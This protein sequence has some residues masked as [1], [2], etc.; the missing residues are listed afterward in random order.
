MRVAVGWKKLDPKQAETGLNHSVFLNVAWDA[1]KPVGMGRIIGDGGYMYLIADVMV[2]PEYQ[3]RGIGRQL[4]EN[5]NAWLDNL[6][7][8]GLCIMVNLM[9]TLGKEEFYQKSGYEV[10]PNESMG[11]GMVRWING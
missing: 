9:A 8:D 7:K 3:G 4:L 10:R 1:E 11:A 2:L 6:G 5:M